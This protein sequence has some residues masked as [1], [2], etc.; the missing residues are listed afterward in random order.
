[1]RAMDDDGSLPGAGGDNSINSDEII[2]V[3][4]GNF[5]RLKGDL[6]V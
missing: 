2:H 5:V 6:V 4:F 1:M 3:I